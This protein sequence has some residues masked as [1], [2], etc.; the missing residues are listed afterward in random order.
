MTDINLPYLQSSAIGSLDTA[1]PLQGG[2]DGM[3][4]LSFDGVPPIYQGLPVAPVSPAVRRFKSSDPRRRVRVPE[5]SKSSDCI[6]PVG[7]WR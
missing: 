3:N 7:L 6:V 4:D 1:F 5:S 2:S